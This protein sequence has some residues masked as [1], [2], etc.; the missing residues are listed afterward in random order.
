VELSPLQHRHC[1]RSVNHKHGARD[2]VLAVTVVIALGLSIGCGGIGQALPSD[3]GD[4]SQAAGV[5]YQ[6]RQYAL[7]GEATTWVTDTDVWGDLGP[8]DAFP[9]ELSLQGSSLVAYRLR[10]LDERAFI[11]LH[12]RAGTARSASSSESALLDFATTG[13]AIAVS[14]DPRPS[15]LGPMCPYIREQFKAN[16]GCPADAKPLGAPT[17]SAV[18]KP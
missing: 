5:R 2:L 1:C 18:T 12:R 8:L 17:P 3:S 11:G 7:E 6:G 15:S 16:N 4:Q 14:T 13:W 10:G 9:R